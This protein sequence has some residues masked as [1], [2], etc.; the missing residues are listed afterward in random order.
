MACGC[1]VAGFPGTAHFPHPYATPAN[2][3]WATDRNVPAA[4]AAIRSAID[5]VRI[6][7]DR[8]HRYLEAGHETAQRFSEEP[9]K[10]ALA[11]LAAGVKER[12]YRA[13]RRVVPALGWKGGLFA[14]WLLYNYDRLGWAGRFLSG[15]SQ[16]TKPVRSCLGRVCGR[17]R[18][19][20]VPVPVVPV[21]VVPG[22][23]ESPG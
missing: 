23:S 11:Q 6:G 8:Y 20:V 16:M 12:D 14:Y 1:L 2:G 21:P 15:I 7:G 17:P 3:L 19:P 4:A 18:I 13:Q 9:V 22:R 5:V 10:K